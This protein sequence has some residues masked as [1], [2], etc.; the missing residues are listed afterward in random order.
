LSQFSR[1]ARWLQRLFPPSVLPGRSDPSIVSDDVSLV[2]TYDAGGLGLEPIFPPERDGD[3]NTDP[4]I[5]TEPEVAIRDY[6]TKIG[7]TAISDMYQMGPGVYARIL[8]LTVRILAGTT[9]NQW[10]L[11]LTAPTDSGIGNHQSLVTPNLQVMASLPVPIAVWNDIIPSG[12]QL[13][14]NSLVGSATLQHRITIA[15]VV[16]PIGSIIMSSRGG[17]TQ[18]TTN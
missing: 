8:G 7:I 15:W 2:Q 12:M 1:R 13:N 9:G 16:A 6:A 5:I 17:F 4:L 18:R 11:D 3:A 10:F 14:C